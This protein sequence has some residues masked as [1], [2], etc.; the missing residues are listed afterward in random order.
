[1]LWRPMEKQLGINLDEKH[2]R[3]QD[4]DCS[5]P[6]SGR[7]S[8]SDARHGKWGQCVLQNEQSARKAEQHQQQEE[9]EKEEEEK[10]DE[11]KEEQQ[12]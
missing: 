11:V 8:N 7:G 6:R 3:E 1:M 5:K 10:E 2:R 9:K 12:Q 4:L